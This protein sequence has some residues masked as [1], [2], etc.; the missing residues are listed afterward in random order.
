MPLLLLHLLVL[1]VLLPSPA[2]ASRF[3]TWLFG[4]EGGTP[5]P[6]PP[7]AVPTTLV[8]LSLTDPHERAASQVTL[9]DQLQ[10]KFGWLLGDQKAV[11]PKGGHRFTGCWRSGM[12]LLS[13]SCR[14]LD[15]PTKQRLA[16][17]L[18]SCHLEEGGRPSV[19]CPDS[20]TD[21]GV[22][23]KRV[24]D[25]A[26]WSTYTDLWVFID[27]YCHG[28]EAEAWQLQTE[29]LIDGLGRTSL[30]AVELLHRAAQSQR[31][32]LHNQEK[33]QALQEDLAVAQRDLQDNLEAS[34]RK[35]MH[36]QEEIESGFG[37]VGE[38]Y[39]QLMD[40][41]TA[42][43]Q[44]QVE[45]L[46]G[47]QRA[48]DEVREFTERMEE[49]FRREAERFHF[50][51]GVLG[52]ATILLEAAVH[53]WR[54]A[55]MGVCVA[56]LWMLAP[57][58]TLVYVKK[59]AA[60]LVLVATVTKLLGT[61]H[62]PLRNLVPAA[63]A[64]DLLPLLTGPGAWSLVYLCGAIVV[65]SVSPLARLKAMWRRW[66]GG[67][68]EDWEEEEVDDED[69]EE[70]DHRRRRWG[71]RQEEALREAARHVV[72]SSSRGEGGG[73]ERMDCGGA[74]MAASTH[75]SG[76]STPVFSA[77]SRSS[78]VQS[79]PMRRSS[80]LQSRLPSPSGSRCGGGGGGA[81]ASESAGYGKGGLATL[82]E[83]AG[84]GEE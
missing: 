69:E 15:V 36:L 6:P 48:N 10:Q 70:G 56:A 55:S 5:K 17:H 12:G 23:L 26:A 53:G 14:E 49:E 3:L 83:E 60:A 76:T 81:A 72:A 41:Q 20:E 13:S 80:R 18:A 73:E 62:V 67:H 58:T 25:D 16:L 79:T 57:A 66:W 33:A 29:A 19:R 37:A 44:R 40:V 45:L 61:L 7:A 43:L 51:K 4:A 47:L 68:K 75:A 1:L 11:D 84:S 2:G 31:Q 28:L 82:Q 54:L 65:L 30:E 35:F 21:V 9:P 34:T 74:A 50:V 59:A 77:T 24:K 64:A 39:E 32:L 27:G 78:S 46:A 22:C 63:W 8:P 42:N 52:H 38:Q 71:V